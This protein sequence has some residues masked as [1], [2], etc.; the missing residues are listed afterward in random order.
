MIKNPKSLKTR[1]LQVVISISIVAIILSVAFIY[2]TLSNKVNELSKKF[3]V[4]Y[5]LK[6]KSRIT[7]PIKKEIALVQNLADSP[8]LR[9]WAQNE[10]N[11]DL[12]AKA[13]AELESYRK[14]FQDSSYFFIIDE[15]KNY[16]FNNS[17]NEYLN[18]QYQY[19]LD[20]ENEDDKW[21][22]ATMEQVDDYYINMNYDRALKTTKLWIDAIIYNKEDKKI[23][24]LGTGF[25]LDRFIQDF[26]KSD[27]KFV[28][29]LLFDSKGYIRAYQ[30]TNLIELCT[31]NKEVSKTDEK[32]IFKLLQGKDADKLQSMMNDLSNNSNK[33]STVKFEMQ[34][35]NRIAAVTYIQSMNW[36]IMTLLDNSKILNMWDFLPTIAV[37]IVSLF[38]IAGAIIFFI[39]RFILKPISHLTEFTKVI[40]DGNYDKKISMDFDNEFGTLADSFNKMANTINEH[41]NHLEKLVEQRTEELEERNK[42]LD[43][44]ASL[45]GLTRLCNRRV[46]NEI[47]NKEWKRL[48]REKRPL[49]LLFLDI[50]FFKQYNDFYGH[51]QGDECL[52]K[53]ASIL[54]EEARR[55]ADLAARYGGEE[56]VILLP[57]TPESGA[58]QK[59]T[60]VKHKIKEVNISHKKSKVSSHVTC[61]IGVATVVPNNNFNA[62][63]FLDAADEALYEAKESGRDRAVKADFKFGNTDIQ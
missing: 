28:T 40:A 21:Y 38:V 7:S 15:S 24:M 19:T 4:Q 25:S 22:F 5:A 42:E 35:D 45:D 56:F 8:I 30:D 1:F 12:K 48:K 57:N 59:A 26:L 51:Q 62:D 13:L 60:E 14:N 52:K 46:F 63:E 55:P 34:N 43:R 54:D 36:F 3:A 29:P 32:T 17:K 37:L 41:I 16:Y 44:L 39:N 31:I 11:T 27:S 6:E 18:N 47:L 50:D 20:E 2:Y 9:K 53:I 23:G 61:S 58:W 33:V 49:S 10:N